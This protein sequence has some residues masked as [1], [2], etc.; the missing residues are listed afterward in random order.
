MD[1]LLDAEV[2][3]A[4]AETNS[5]S[6]AATALGL[7][8]SAVSRR[9]SALESKLSIR[10]LE[11]TTRHLRLTEAGERYLAHAVAGLTHLKDAET[12]ARLHS[13]AVIGHV[14]ILAPMAFGKLHVAPHVPGILATY[15]ELSIDLLLDDK[16]VNPLDLGC[17]LALQFG[18]LPVSSL[19]CRKL[20]NLGSVV[21]ASPGYL[22]QK[23][24][25]AV[26]SDLLTHNCILFSYSDNKDTWVFKS[27]FGQD[28]I[29]V[30]GN[31]QVNNGEV[32]CEAALQGLGVARLPAFVAAPYVV[33]GELVQV[34]KEHELPS[35]PLYAVHAARTLVPR[36]IRVL[37]DRFADLYGSARP[38]WARELQ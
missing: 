23:P 32:L 16:R 12:A 26:P 35:K 10:L 30:S 14:R 29:A 15:P 11:R 36:K 8:K 33:S 21:C 19:I 13:E 38:C 31:F 2:F 6:K 20:A 24:A 5:F 17:D 7:S 9:I 22:K 3:A 25:I 27:D 1:A 18:D 28:E 34:L 37:I 4:V